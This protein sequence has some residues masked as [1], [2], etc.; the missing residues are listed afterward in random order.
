[1][2]MIFYKTVIF[3]TLLFVTE[4]AFSQANVTT[5]QLRADSLKSLTGGDMRIFADLLPAVSDSFDLGSDVQTFRSGWVSELNS[6]IFAKNTITLVGGFLRV[7][8]NTGKTRQLT[9]EIATTI[10][11]D[12]TMTLK[13]LVEFRNGG[14]FE[15]VRVESLAVAYSDTSKRYWVTRNLDGSGA[16]EWYAGTPYS[17]VGQRGNGWI[18]LSSYVSPRISLWQQHDSTYNNKT[19]ILRI[20]DLNGYL[21]YSTSIYGLGMGKSTGNKANITIDTVNGI[22]IRNGTTN[23]FTVDND[24]NVAITAAVTLTNAASIAISGF[25]ND[26]GYVTTVGNKT[27]YQATTPSPV[28]T[29]DIWMDT[30]NAGQWIMKRWNGTT[31]KPMSVYMDGNGLWAGTIN[32]GNLVGGMIDADWLVADSIKAGTFTGLIFRTK[33]SG[34]RVEIT[35]GV[36]ATDNEMNFYET[37]GGS[38]VRIGSSV[39]GAVPGIVVTDG[40]ILVNNEGTSTPY[41]ISSYVLGSTGAVN[42]AFLA[43]STGG[44]SNYSFYGNSGNIYNAGDVNITGAYKINGTALTY[45]DVGAIPYSDTTSSIAKQWELDLKSWIGHAHAWSDITSGVPTTLSGYGI[46]DAHYDSSTPA[47]YYISSGTT[48]TSKAITVIPVNLGGTVKNVLTVD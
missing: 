29:G 15:Y 31:W 22:R 40:N 8:K 3:F 16:N 19:E 38:K 10:V 23:K 25:N 47:A 20:G 36:G 30:T 2:R 14:R 9:S 43:S 37:T 35:S 48:W 11:F 45:S 12:Q 17:V 44:T 24:G 21:D 26:I 32:V 42:V 27:Y 28:V 33:A 6:T 4:S 1:M 34:K 7:G 18:D 41:G 39:I 5:K 46:T 13:D